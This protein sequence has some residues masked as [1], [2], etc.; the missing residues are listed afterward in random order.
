[1]S[2]KA[3][4]FDFAAEHAKAVAAYYPPSL[5]AQI[6]AGYAA[7]PEPVEPQ[8]KPRRLRLVSEDERL[9]DPRHE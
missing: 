9:D 7:M 3:D 1:M 5:L 8:P 2:A 4:T 6:R